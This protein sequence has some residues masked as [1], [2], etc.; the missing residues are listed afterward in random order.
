MLTTDL[1][2]KALPLAPARRPATTATQ[3]GPSG[4]WLLP[5][6]AFGLTFWAGAVL[7]L[8]RVL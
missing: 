7:M 5:A 1:P 6:A 8:V 2:G 3:R 4:W